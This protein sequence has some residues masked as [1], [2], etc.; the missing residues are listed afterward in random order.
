VIIT[1]LHLIKDTFNI[2]FSYIK[3]NW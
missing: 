1:K 2:N 3:T